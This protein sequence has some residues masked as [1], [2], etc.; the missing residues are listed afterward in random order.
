MMQQRLLWFALVFTTFLYGILAYATERNYRLQPI[1]L[2]L[3]RPFVIAAY[4][5]GLALFFLALRM[6]QR[7]V[8][9][10][11]LL[12][13]VAIMGLLAAMLMRDW[14]IYLPAWAFALVGFVRV[15]P[16]EDTARSSGRHPLHKS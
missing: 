12:D 8:V 9:Q 6:S 4:V 5:I 14:R 2:M 1:E 10:L 3:R 11:A 13:A 16:S 15:Y 7:F